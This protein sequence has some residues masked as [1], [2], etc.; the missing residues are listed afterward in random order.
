LRESEFWAL[1]DV[2]FNVERG[3][4]IGIVGKNGSG[5]STLLKILNGTIKPTQGS[6]K[7]YG[8]IRLLALGTGFNPLL[9]GMENIKVA[10]ALFGFGVNKTKQLIEEIVDFCELKK[11]I[12][13]PVKTY[14]SGMYARLG[15]GIAVHTDPEILLVDEA[16]SVGD[17]SFVSKCM[18]KIK[19]F[20]ANGG[21]IVLVTHAP[22]AV[23]SICDK[24]LWIHDGEV[25]S[26]GPAEPVC[27]EYEKF[28][29]GEGITA[30]PTT[31]LDDNISSL[32]IEVPDKVNHSESMSI[33]VKVV[34]K[35]CI[36]YKMNLFISI[37]D[38]NQT[39]ILYND[40]K[41]NGHCFTADQNFFH[42]RVDYKEIFLNRGK[43]FINI[44]LYNEDHAHRLAFLLNAASFQVEVPSKIHLGGIMHLPCAFFLEEQLK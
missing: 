3:E 8:E 17:I 29:T 23:R 41:E 31:F 32:E 14:S 42:F 11:F 27:L 9:S 20:K 22:Y 6:A 30:T 33:K 40:S 19:E 12:D 25:K 39:M 15:F 36:D 43:Y 2:S 7:I 26:Y 44:L 16:L 10:C 38:V 4:S 21:T 1:K 34:T 13:S 28:I 18:R 24:A 35:K 5:K 37:F